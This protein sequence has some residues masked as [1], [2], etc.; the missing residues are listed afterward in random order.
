MG[1]HADQLTVAKLG[2]I[3]VSTAGLGMWKFM[4]QP[5]IGLPVFAMGTVATVYAGWQEVQ[6]RANTVQDKINAG[7]PFTITDSLTDTSTRVKNN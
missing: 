6:L 5:Q 2:G 3:V 1:L 7:R 4:N